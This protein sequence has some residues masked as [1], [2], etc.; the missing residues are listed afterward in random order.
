MKPALVFKTAVSV[1]ALLLICLVQVSAQSLSGRVIDSGGRPIPGAVVQA[2]LAT[3][4][5]PWHRQAGPAVTTVAADGNWTLTDIAPGMWVVTAWAAAAVGPGANE[6]GDSG[7]AASSPPE[8]VPVAR[9][10]L[11]A[12]ESPGAQSPDCDLVLD[13]G[14]G[15]ERSV[16]GTLGGR[17]G[18]QAFAYEV[19]ILS[20]GISVRGSGSVTISVSGSAETVLPQA[21]SY[22]AVPNEAG[23]FQFGRIRVDGSELLTVDALPVGACGSW[24]SHTVLTTPLAL[25]ADLRSDSDVTISVGLESL[26]DVTLTAV[27]EELLPDAPEGRDWVDFSTWDK[28]G[29]S[30]S[31]GSRNSTWR[32]LLRNGTYL[33]RASAGESASPLTVL[34]LEGPGG[35]RQLEL[36][37]EPCPTVDAT[38]R[39]ETG[40]ALALRRLTLGVDGI[41]DSLRPYRVGIPIRNGIGSVSGVLPGEYPAEVRDEYGNTFRVRIRVVAGEGSILV[42]RF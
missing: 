35:A 26:H 39:D 10:I 5:S 7:S 21:V 16:H 22:S 1:A 29:A 13:L 41:G 23:E 38:F 6:D 34:V 37:L 17:F 42:T 14:S 3:E 40:V 27:R 20:G 8:G 12:A 11:C 28:R 18:P 32:G 15:T 24:K 33:V 31:S 4:E 2:R 30:H 25:Q 36:P 19:R 9:A